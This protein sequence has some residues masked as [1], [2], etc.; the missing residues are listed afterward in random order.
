MRK[1]LWED[2]SNRHITITE[3]G[4]IVDDFNAIT[5][6]KETS[7]PGRLDQRRCSGFNDWIF[8]LGLIDVGFIGAK[9]TWT[10]GSPPLNIQGCTPR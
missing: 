9:F 7:R 6:S 8:E 4:L 3:P 5:S 2:L 1:M 10:R